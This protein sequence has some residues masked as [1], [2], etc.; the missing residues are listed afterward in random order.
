LWLAR[1]VGPVKRVLSALAGRSVTVRT[2]VLAAWR[3]P[4]PPLDAARAFGRERRDRWPVEPEMVLLDDPRLGSLLGTRVVLL[5]AG[6]ER[7]LL[8]VDCDGARAF[9]PSS[10]EHVQALARAELLA[11]GARDPGMAPGDV[12]DLAR[13]GLMLRCAQL[14]GGRLPPA[15]GIETITQMGRGPGGGWVVQVSVEA[16]DTMRTVLAMQ[17]GQVTGL[18][19]RGPKQ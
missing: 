15:V 19:H 16:G 17:D 14:Q 2:D 6:D 7:S 4:A 5:R 1:E 9:D 3:A 8:A 13:A 18:E 10:R 12:G 11:I